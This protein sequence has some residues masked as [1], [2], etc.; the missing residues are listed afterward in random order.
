MNHTYLQVTAQIVKADGTNCVAE[1]K[2]APTNLWLHSLFSQ[3]DVSLNEKLITPSTN[4]YPYRAYLE[5]L[6]TYG[7]EAK[8]THLQAALWKKDTRGRMDLGVKTGSNNVTNKG[9]IE[10]ANLTNLSKAVELM[11]K[12]HVDIFHQ[13][14]YMLNGVD[15]RIRLVRSKTPFSMMVESAGDFRVKVT[16]AVLHVRKIKLSPR[17]QMMHIKALEKSN[18]KYPIRRIETKVF[19]VPK[20]NLSANQENLF[21]GQ[22]PKRV[23][24]GCVDNDAFNG[25]FRIRSI[26]SITD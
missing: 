14:P 21:L 7:E 8:G 1:D 6:L 20:G 10:R 26:S 23:V 25:S 19:S 11:G 2:V 16:D 24:I 5:T 12:L 15:V 18:A 3:V 9:A 13:D 17:M 22:L 4:T